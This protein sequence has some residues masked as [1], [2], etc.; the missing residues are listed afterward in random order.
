MERLF[1]AGALDV[2]FSPIQMKK[3]RPATM[4]TVICA[5]ETRE[6]MAEILFLETTTFG[7]RHTQMERFVL[8]RE[9]RSVT[10]EYGEIRVKVGSWKGQQMSASPEYESVKAAAKEQGVPAKQVSQAA[11]RVFHSEELSASRKINSV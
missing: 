2:F 4:L 9:F 10:T 5:T 6:T 7:I 11:L 8:E 3:N 1:E